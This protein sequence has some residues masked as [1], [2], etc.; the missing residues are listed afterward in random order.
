MQSLVAMEMLTPPTLTSSNMAF[1][2]I[3]LFQINSSWWRMARIERLD[4]WVLAQSMVNGMGL[5]PFWPIYPCFNLTFEDV[6]LPLHNQCAAI[7]TRSA[8]L[9]NFKKGFADSVK[10]L[11]RCPYADKWTAV[12][13]VSLC[14][15][16][17]GF[18]AH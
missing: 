3:V 5:H 13:A 10:I 14:D 11:N 7:Y 1:N 6:W 12:H 4:I 9:Q 15:P 8:E 16:F 2:T 18:W 17:I